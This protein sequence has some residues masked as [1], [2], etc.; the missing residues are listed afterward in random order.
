MLCDLTK[1]GQ[2]PSCLTT[3][4]YELCSV[5]CERYSSL[6]DGK[7]LL[8]RSLEI[9]FRHLDPQDPRVAAELTHTEHHRHMVDAVFESRDDEAIGDL[10]HAW[11]SIDNDG[12]GPYASLDMCVRHLVGLRPSSRR[13]RR[14]VIRAVELIGSRRFG[15]VGVEESVDLLD[16]LRVG[17]EDIDDGTQWATLLLDTIQHP[18]GIR[19]LSY[20]YWELLVELSIPV[21]RLPR[22]TAWGSRIMRSLE[23]DEEWDKLE[24]WMGVIWM[25]GVTTEDL[26]RVM[27][28][29]FRQRPCAIGKLEQWM[30]RWSKSHNRVVPNVFQQICEQ[31]RREATEQGPPKFP[32][33]VTGTLQASFIFLFCFRP[34]SPAGEGAG[35]SARVPQPALVLVLER[36]E[37][38]LPLSLFPDVQTSS[39]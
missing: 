36:P 23:E 8:L 27:L 18:E 1:W 26:E 4:A 7:E 9:G 37:H 39:V 24:C 29:L 32:S 22:Y 33:V 21:P 34:T 25:A 20:P 13:L 19:C 2:R 12:N 38:L 28:L 30:E 11:T 17:V 31:A 3:M 15:Q 16:T 5:I 6:V 10:L 35:G 14:L